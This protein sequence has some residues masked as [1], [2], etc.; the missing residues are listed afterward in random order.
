ML[1]LLSAKA[2]GHLPGAK[3]KRQ[4]VKATELS[5]LENACV[6]G[7]FLNANANAEAGTSSGSHQKNEGVPPPKKRI[8][9]IRTWNR[10]ASTRNFS[11]HWSYD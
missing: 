3:E 5:S 2:P 11:V 4:A 9:D 1:I 10:S 7:P 8:G 6:Y